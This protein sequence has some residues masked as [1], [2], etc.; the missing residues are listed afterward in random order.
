MYGDI[1]NVATL[2]KK[3]FSNP[4]KFFPTDN[5]PSSV[6]FDNIDPIQYSLNVWF[7]RAVGG[8]RMAVSD[9]YG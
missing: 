2:N 5:Q 3:I 7:M 6:F 1:D 4:L 8:V 9:T